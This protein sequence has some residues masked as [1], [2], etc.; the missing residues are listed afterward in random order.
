[1]ISGPSWIDSTRYDISAKASSATSVEAMRSMLRS[2]L[3]DRFQLMVHRETKDLPVYAIVVAKNG[4]RHLEKAQPGTPSYM[5][6]GTFGSRQEQHWSLKN[7]SMASF[8]GFLT[9]PMLDRPVV[10]MTGLEGG[11]DFAFDYP[12]RD[13]DM[14]GLDYMLMAVFPSVDDQLGLKVEP[15]KAPT[16]VLVIDQTE[17]APTEN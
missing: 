5:Q 3:A 13:P 16:E 6:P 12:P 7:A 11:F 9:R 17:K 14:T 1:L 10:D 8:A 2:L 15:R 4:P